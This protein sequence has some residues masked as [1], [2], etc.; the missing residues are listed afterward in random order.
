[1]P[2]CEVALRCTDPYG[3]KGCEFHAN[4]C[5]IPRGDKRLKFCKHADHDDPAFCSHPEARRAALAALLDE[6][7]EAQADRQRAKDR[8]F[9]RKINEGICPLCGKALEVVQD[10]P[11]TGFDGEAHMRR[12]RVSCSLS[13]GG[14]A[15]IGWYERM[16]SEK[17]S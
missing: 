12:Q 7:Q 15:G 10:E 16:V 13:A 8:E 5:G 2:T 17:K 14:C 3:L 9:I 6:M 4:G 1:M 11:W